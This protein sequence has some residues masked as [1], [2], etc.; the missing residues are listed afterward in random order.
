MIQ[1][2]NKYAFLVFHKDYEA[3]LEKLRTLGVL[4]VKE[5][6]NAREVDALRAILSER[7][8]CVLTP[9]R[10]VLPRPIFLKMKRQDVPSSQR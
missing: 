3:F 4:H 6:K 2:M 5:Q 7:A 9:P 10:S 1:P 8:H